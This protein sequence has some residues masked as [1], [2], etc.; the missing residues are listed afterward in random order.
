M[1]NFGYTSPKSKVEKIIWVI[2]LILIFLFI[3]YIA[4]HTFFEN[5]LL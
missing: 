2:A 4:L 5:T 1:A 3:L